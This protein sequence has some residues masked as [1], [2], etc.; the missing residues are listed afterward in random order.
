MT[1]TT[2][3][4]DRVF[5]LG[6]HDPMENAYSVRAK[7]LYGVVGFT[8]SGLILHFTRLTQWSIL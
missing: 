2:E 6:N 7:A 3:D 1:F 4:E 8:T 5:W